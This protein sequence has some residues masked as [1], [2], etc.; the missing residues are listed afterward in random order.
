MVIR[1]YC[2]FTGPSR[3]GLAIQARKHLVSPAHTVCFTLDLF[4]GLDSS[5][6]IF[7]AS[8]RDGSCEIHV[9]DV[10]KEAVGT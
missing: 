8:L 3:Q 9:M 2:R 10:G 7:T 6:S 1:G 4:V 5:H